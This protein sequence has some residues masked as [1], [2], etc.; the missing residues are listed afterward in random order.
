M[1]ANGCIERFFRTLKEQLLWV[2]HFDTI[3]ELGQAL[4]EF[5]ETY[6]RNWLIERLGFK[7]PRQA[8]EDLLA[9]GVAA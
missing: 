3:E 2:R 7:S 6:N 4:F 9:I 1:W 5:K 8:R